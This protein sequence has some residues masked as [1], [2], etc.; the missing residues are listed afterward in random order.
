M[1][2]VWPLAPTEDSEPSHTHCVIYNIGGGGWGEN[3]PFCQLAHCSLVVGLYSSSSKHGSSEYSW[4]CILAFPTIACW[5][6]NGGIFCLLPQMERAHDYI[7][8]G[9]SV[10]KNN[11]SVFN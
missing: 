11:L 5:G 7:F 6:I 3:T 8:L 10:C 1:G 9:F 4:L 2:K